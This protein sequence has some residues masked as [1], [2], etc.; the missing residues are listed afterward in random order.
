[1]TV[2]TTVVG[3]Y[4]K[5][6][7]EG[8]EFA[9]RK[10]LWAVDRGEATDADVKAAQDD[11]VR[12]IIAEQAEAG[13]GLVTDG[14]ARWADA[15]TRFAEGIEGFTIGGLIRYFDNNTY[16]RQPVI[17]GPVSRRLPITVEE[18]TFAKEN[19]P[20][21][22][23]AVLVG[24]YTLA[25]LSQN[26]SEIEINDLV[27]DL[28]VALNDEARDLV[29]AGAEYV[30]FDEPILASVPGYTPGDLAIMRDASE[31]LVEGVEATTILQTFFGDVTGQGSALFELPFDVFGLDLV[32]GPANRD[33]L[34]DLPEGKTL[35]A[36]IVDARNT[37]LEPQ[38]VLV[39]LLEELNGTVP[40]ERLWVSPS[41]GLEYLPRE[42]AQAKCRRLAEAT[43]R[44]EEVS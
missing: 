9:L 4:P 8:G 6:P 30:Q 11:L 40:A 3:S 31:V 22:V 38:D 17:K 42:A 44:F 15:Q 13:V 1:M 25:A 28:A 43:A 24:P 39:D 5:P 37:K 23:K 41:A 36:G 26:D 21:P 14:Q 18:F 27:H 34:G 10:T 20:V 12:E 2:K 29:A 35:Q 19:S 32:A 16:Y 33:L 7:H